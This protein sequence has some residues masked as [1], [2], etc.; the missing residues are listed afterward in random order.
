MVCH[1]DTWVVI[2]GPW[3]HKGPFYEITQTASPT[4]SV[5]QC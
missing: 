3:S 4:N 5:V 1:N 2:L